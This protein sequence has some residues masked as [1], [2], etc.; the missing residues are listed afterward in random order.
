MV[1]KAAGMAATVALCVFAIYPIGSVLRLAFLQ[2]TGG[3]GFG[4]FTYYTSYPGFLNALWHTLDVSLW[5]TLITVVLAYG[6]CFALYQTCVPWKQVWRGIIMLPLIVP[7]LMQAL[8]VQFILGRNGIMNQFFGTDFDVYG[9]WGIL[10]SNVVYALPHAFLVLQVALAASSAQQYEAAQLFGANGR[11][12][13][14]SITLPHS[15]YGILSAVFLV[16]AINISEFGNPMVIGGDYN[17]LATEIYNQVIGQANLNMGAV[18]GVFLLAP[19]MATV[20]IEQYLARRQSMIANA[21]KITYVPK[22]NRWLDRAFLLYVGIIAS[23]ICSIIVVVGLS[24]ISRLWPYDLTPTLAHFSFGAS[25]VF[26]VLGNSVKMALLTAVLGGIL[27]T[28]LAWASNALKPITTKV[29]YTLA[30]LPASIPGMIIG[31]GYALSF[32]GTDIFSDSIFGV[33][34]LMSICTVYHYHAQAFLMLANRMKQLDK[35]LDQASSILGASSW[36]TFR[37]V[38]LPLIWPAIATVMVFYFIQGM[39]TLSALIFLVTPQTSLAAVSVLTLNDTGQLAQ[40][41]ALSTMIM[42]IVLG[43]WVIAQATMK[44]NNRRQGRLRTAPNPVFT[45]N[46]G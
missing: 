13:F 41:A 18:I 26:D 44:L 37:K 5:A 39:V 22:P 42:L 24:S 7:S 40:A 12:M 30:I 34:L 33:I 38:T 36:R 32:S 19:V 21:G 9:F 8:G 45:N 43:T 17:V 14:F 11:R 31:F 4:N 2:E 10:I 25:S 6:F 29:I 46:A 28:M 23:I 16:F 27:V 20:L 35:A 15:R 1:I 3:W